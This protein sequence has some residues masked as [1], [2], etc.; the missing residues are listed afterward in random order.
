MENADCDLLIAGGGVNGCGIARDAAGRGLKVILAEAGDLASATS[1]ASTKL[2][3]GGLR[4]LEFYEFSLVRKAL[5]E[6]RTLLEMAPHIIWPQRF[7]L[8]HHA[9]LRPFWML[10]LGLFLYDHLGER[11]LLPPSR[12]VRLAGSEYGRPLKPVY[13]R[14]F[15]YSDCAVDDSRLVIL[16]AVDAAERGA[17][18]LPR[19]KVVSAE[20]GRASWRVRLKHAMTG[21]T[22][23][24][25]AR[26]LINATGPW[27]GTFLTDILGQK[28]PAH[29]VRPVKGSHIIV[30]RLYD[31]D[32]AYLFQ[33]RDGRI[34]FAIPYHRRF[35][36]I[37]TTDVDID[38]DPGE[39]RI[40]AEEIDYLC[41]AVS[42]YFAEP[43]TPD[44]VVHTFTGVRPL[45]D[46]GASEA[47][48]ATRDYVIAVDDDGAALVNIFG[49]KLT[50]YRKLAEA[51]L[52]KLAT[53]MPVAGGPWTEGADLP[54]G[55]FPAAEFADRRRRF[56]AAHPFLGDELAERLFRAYGARAET[57]LDGV[58]SLS[59]MGHHFGAGLHAREVEYLIANE[60]AMSA[61]DIVW[62]RSR[63]GL[64]MTADE[65]AGLSRWL[66]ANTATGEPS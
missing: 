61:D 65:V 40:T 11:N 18:I 35:T 60:W 22:R 2:I 59:G 12:A 10:R 15:E 42:E 44:N 17:E 29:A 20:R 57:M 66:A 63:L 58:T 23:T 27:A 54:G 56:T 39:A 41:R 7:I 1:S 52:D 3:H 43:V 53:A 47:A 50:T 19:W 46:D 32:R 49:G 9:G 34:V 33:N 64:F 38:G 36:L 51:V 5:I 13:R 30:P 62:R 45:Y 21:A 31:H 16:N 25:T 14:G 8:P 37:G 6:R 24:V 48:Q 26:A 4:Y 55:D 28:A